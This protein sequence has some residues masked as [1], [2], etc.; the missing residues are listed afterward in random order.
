MRGKD[1]LDIEKITPYL[2]LAKTLLII[3]RQ[4]YPAMKFILICGFIYV[5]HNT[6]EVTAGGI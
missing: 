4:E 5:R 1:V 3:F 2:F 6:G